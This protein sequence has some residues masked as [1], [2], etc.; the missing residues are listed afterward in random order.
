MGSYGMMGTAD[1]GVYIQGL[2]LSSAQV[3]AGTP[4]AWDCESR[5]VLVGLGISVC[6]GVRLGRITV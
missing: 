5:M 2:G 4:A 6:Q 3:A 1:C